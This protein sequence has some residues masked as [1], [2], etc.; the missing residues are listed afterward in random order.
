MRDILI[1][2]DDPAIASVVSLLLADEGWEVD[3]ESKQDL[4]AVQARVAARR[5]DCVL[6]DGASGRDYGDSWMTAEWLASLEPPIP[7]VMLTAHGA[8]VAEARA[9]DTERSRRAKFGAAVAKPFEID[10]L[11]AAVDAAMEMRPEAHGPVGRAALTTRR[12]SRGRAAR[13]AG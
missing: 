8:A 13:S 11:L 12:R 3:V 1:V 10:E 5:P 4:A 2:D 6:L 9:K 7:A